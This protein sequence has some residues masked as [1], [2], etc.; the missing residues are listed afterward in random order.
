MQSSVKTEG[1]RDRISDRAVDTCRPS[2]R[3]ISGLRGIQFRESVTSWLH[4]I[5]FL[6]PRPQWVI[7]VDM[8]MSALSSAIDG[9]GHYHVR[10]RPV[11]LR[12]SCVR[13]ANNGHNRRSSGVPVSVERAG[14]RQAAGYNLRYQA[15]FSAANGLFDAANG[16]PFGLEA[17]KRQR[18]LPKARSV[19]EGRKFIQPVPSAAPQTSYR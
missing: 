9:T 3:V 11:C 12:P 16:Q 8:A 2:D 15:R 14:I 6:A 13:P 1:A 4:R 5:V 7:R 19:D 17:R 10:P 18:T